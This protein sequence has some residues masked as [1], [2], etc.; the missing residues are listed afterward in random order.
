[1]EGEACSGLP[2]ADDALHACLTELRYKYEPYVETL[3]SHLLMPLP[4]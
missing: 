1:M 3:A 4:S 2:D